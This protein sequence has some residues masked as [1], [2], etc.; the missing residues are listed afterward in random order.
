MADV[1]VLVS[2]WEGTVVC[3]HRFHC[4]DARFH[5]EMLW[6]CRYV[7]VVCPGTM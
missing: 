1:L 7:S 4:S 5:M 6:F 2:V 3:S